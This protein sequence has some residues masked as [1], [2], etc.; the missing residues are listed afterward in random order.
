[1]ICLLFLALL[2]AILAI[3]ANLTTTDELLMFDGHPR[4]R[5]AVLVN[6]D[7]NE[8]CRIYG[9]SNPIQVIENLPDGPTLRTINQQEWL[10]VAAECQQRLLSLN[11]KPTGPSNQLDFIFP[12]TRW[13]GTGDVARNFEDLGPHVAT[14]MCCRDHDFC[15][16][17]M[18]P[19]TCKYGLCNT[20][21]FTKSHCDC[22]DRFRECLLNAANDPA[23]IP[24]GFLYFDVGAISCYRQT[25]DCVNKVFREPIELTRRRKRQYQARQTNLQHGWC[26]VPPQPFKKSVT[27][28]RS[29]PDGIFRH[30]ISSMSD[31]TTRV[32]QVAG[33]SLSVHAGK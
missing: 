22:D 30:V 25:P 31:V 14:D 13:C 16:D 10:V 33:S 15:Q 6:S 4:S 3:A 5:R 7:P 18:K 23:S 11:Q 17:T 27:F 24:V 12:G 1:M 21:V 19:G 29:Q 32:K 2:Q 8:P 26:F 20:S 28:R 9:H